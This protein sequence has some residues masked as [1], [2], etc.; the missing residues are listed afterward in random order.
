MRYNTIFRTLIPVII[1]LL[2]APCGSSAQQEPDTLFR[3]NNQ[4]RAYG[5]GNGPLVFIDQVHHNFHT[6]D[7]G[8]FAFGKL[9]EQD[10]YH[11]QGFSN[12]VISMEALKKCRILVIANALASS[13]TERWILPTPS[14]F[15]AEEI[16]SIRDWVKNGGS[17]LLIADHIHRQGCHFHRVGVQDARRS[18]ACAQ[19]QCNPLVVAARYCMEIQYSNT[20]ENPGRISPGCAAGFRQRQSCRFRRGRHVYGPD[21]EWRD[22]GWVQLPGCSAECPIHLKRNPLA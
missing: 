9:L 1:S 19:F 10:G 16:L 18:H 5:D 20:Q 22:A 7:G 4:H 14:A 2:V 13:N 8:F 11:V 17:L 21:R 12:A 15:R 6:K 3:Y